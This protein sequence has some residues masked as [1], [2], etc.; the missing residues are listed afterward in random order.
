ML[1]TERLRSFYARHP[2]LTDVGIA[3]ILLGVSMAEIEWSPGHP[4]WGRL[5]VVALGTLPF[6]LRRQSSPFAA[7][8]MLLAAAGLEAMQGVPAATIVAALAVFYRIGLDYS[9]P[10]SDWL[11][12]AVVLPFSG[13]VLG[14]FIFS[15]GELSSVLLSLVLIPG[16]WLL[17]E[18][19]GARRANQRELE[20]RNRLLQEAREDQIALAVELER[21]AIARELHD[22]VT[23]NV[24]VMVIQASAARRRVDSEPDQVRDSLQSIEAA[25]RQ[26]LA[27]M[28][29]V[30]GVMRGESMLEP[31]P[32]LSSL[33]E[34]VDQVRAAGIAVDITIE[35]EQQA[36]PGPLE[37]SAYRIIQEALTNTIMHGGDNVTAQVITSYRPDR[38]VIDILDNGRGSHN[39]QSRGHGLIGIRE[40]AALFGGTADL[41]NQDERG[42]RVH[43]E[44]PVT[45]ST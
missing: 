21:T 41:G 25:G 2:M 42:Y 22:I 4:Q 6:M 1:T 3:F 36:L 34:L 20:D 33:G 10:L 28:R 15:T 5:T 38:L 43:V 37:L 19:M 40:R 35:G 30:L 17:S 16:V 27:E 9:K 44:L 14:R 7:A 31:Q 39:G 29:L 32:G 45:G 12:I 23:H 11:R 8:I 26:A 18:T 13:V 24:S